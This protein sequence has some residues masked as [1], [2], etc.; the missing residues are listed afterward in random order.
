MLH[1]IE[2]RLTDNDNNAF[3]LHAFHL[4]TSE[5]LTL[6]GHRLSDQKVVMSVAP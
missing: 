6:E 4:D 3:L 2:L 5:L 1:K